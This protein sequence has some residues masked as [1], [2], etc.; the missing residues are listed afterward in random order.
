MSET[1]GRDGYG[2]ASLFL[3]FLGGAAAG[4]AVALLIAPKAGRE[5]R[6][7]LA[8]YVRSGKEKTRQLPEAVKAASIAARDAFSEAIGEKH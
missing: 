8:D 4:A 6:E 5:T 2:A 3:A 1:N 7:Q